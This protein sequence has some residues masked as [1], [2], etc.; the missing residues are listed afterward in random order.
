[1]NHRLTCLF[2]VISLCAA[3]QAS[4]L[5]VPAEYPTIQSAL[6]ATHP[7][8]TVLVSDGLYAEAVSSPAHAVSLIGQVAIDNQ[9]PIIDPSTLPDSP[10]LSCL[11]LN[12]SSATI[13]NFVFRNSSQMY[14]RPVEAE[15]G[16]VLNN[17]TAY[18]SNCKF[19]ST[20]V[21]IHIY[22]SDPIELLDCELLDCQSGTVRGDRVRIHAI[23]CTFKA[24]GLTCDS[25][26]RFI[27]CLF[28]SVTYRSVLF[29]RGD[30]YMESCI[31]QRHINANWP[32][33]DAGAVNPTIRNCIF[34]DCMPSRAVFFIQHD[35]SQDMLFENNLFENIVPS[36]DIERGGIT[37]GAFGNGH[38]GLATFRNN[39]FQNIIA[40]G[41]GKAL[42]LNLPMDVIIVGNRF[43]NCG[44]PD[45]TVWVLGATCTAF[46]N[47]FSRTDYAMETSRICD[48]PFNFWG[49]STGPY[50]ANLNPNGRGDEV[51]DSVLFFPWLTDSSL[52]SETRFEL[53]D[54]FQLTA[55]PNPFNSQTRLRIDAP[56]S[57]IASIE[58]YN[59]LGQKVRE[60]Y[61]GPLLGQRE[62]LISAD[63][64][65][66]G[67]YFLSV[68]DILH[69]SVSSTH[70][71]ALIR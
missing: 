9:R 60:I 45:P 23:N 21:A 10:E 30:L 58:M 42:L 50:N 64:L 68:R 11:T 61:K 4:I 32:T 53:P 17:C 65:P 59:L 66:S 27:N 40:P 48:A 70:K 69:N 57:F 28:D 31:I 35:P 8:D 34:R 20:N 44:G 16:V 36:N 49:D 38:G 52:A 2:A 19:D 43:I 33:I 71:I 37:I 26:S 55:F 13:Q 12:G 46:Y 51:S 7:F 39:T 54:R 62:F 67:I 25:G 24:F 18:F 15:G 56:V 47:I 63:N 3:S 5:R 14:P 1:M 29:P 22:G 6:D 41:S